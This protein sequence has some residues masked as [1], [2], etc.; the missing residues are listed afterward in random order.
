MQ[1]T[2]SKTTAEHARTKEGSSVPRFAV[3]K[4]KDARADAEPS[5]M[6]FN[7]LSPV[8][9]EGAKRAMEA[10]IAQ[11]SE[12]K[13]LFQMPGFSLV[14]AWFK[15]GYPLPRHTHNCD[16]LYYVISGSLILGHEELGPGDGFFV[17]K[18]VPYTYKPG[19]SGVEVLEF[20]ATNA[21]DIKVLADNP[22][23]W[24]GAVK[25]ALAQRS[26]WATEK[27]PSVSRH[28]SRVL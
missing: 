21:F 24:E 18:D 1:D 2:G 26:A 19:E 14:Y 8:A 13:V 20:R 3:F 5:L 7:P 16:C 22:L 15:S 9:A 4:G 23:F 27:P 6:E 10:G 17:G 25:T 28:G 11:G 12:L